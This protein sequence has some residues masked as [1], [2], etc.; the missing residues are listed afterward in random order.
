[1][2]HPYIG[3]YVIVRTYSSGVHCGFLKS[4]DYCSTS[5]ILENT[6][7]IWEWKGAFTLSTVANKGVEMAK[8]PDAIPE[9]FLSSSIEIIPTSEAA[10]KQLEE[11]EKWG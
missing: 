8:M 7:R 11:T 2:A 4:Y 10:Q 9:I 1:M 6:R 5:L 3:Q